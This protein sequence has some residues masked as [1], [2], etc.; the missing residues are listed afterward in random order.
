MPPKLKKRR[1]SIKFYRDDLA[2]FLNIKPSTLRM[3]ISRKKV[4]LNNLEEFI[5]FILYM[6]FK[7]DFEKRV[8]DKKP[9]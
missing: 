1:R 4:N 7:D 2:K 9:V 3:I 8:N 5:E 6:K